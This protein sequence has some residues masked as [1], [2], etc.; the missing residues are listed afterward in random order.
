MT[1]RATAT[2]HFHEVL[3]QFRGIT[4]VGDATA[5]RSGHLQLAKDAALTV[6]DAYRSPSKVFVVILSGNSTAPDDFSVKVEVTCKSDTSDAEHP[7]DMATIRGD[8]I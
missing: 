7:G 1:W 2:G 6:V 5:E 3:S 8:R 4:S